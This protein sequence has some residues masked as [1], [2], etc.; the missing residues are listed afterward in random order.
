M[1]RL[2]H[3]RLLASHARLATPAATHGGAHRYRLRHGIAHLHLTGTPELAATA[4]QRLETWFERFDLPGHEAVATLTGDLT[5]T[6]HRLPEAGLAPWHDWLGRNATLFARARDPESGRGMVLQTAT[7]HADDSPV[8]AAAEDWLRGEGADTWYLRR[9]RRP[10]C[11]DRPSY[12]DLHLGGPLADGPSVVP[13]G[14]SLIA[15]L[16]QDGRVGLVRAKPRMRWRSERADAVAIAPLGPTRFASVTGGGH[17]LAW[18]APL[19][20]PVLLAR[21]DSLGAE[22]APARLVNAGGGLVVADHAT[23]DPARPEARLRFI[24]PDGSVSA[25]QTANLGPLQGL[26]AVGDTDLVA[27][28]MRR[29][30]MWDLATT[31]LRWQAEADLEELVAVAPVGDGHLLAVSRPAAAT[32]PHHPETHLERRLMP[33]RND[34]PMWRRPALGEVPF[35]DGIQ[36]RVAWVCPACE[37]EQAEASLDHVPPE[38]TRPDPA[39]TREE[40][41][42]WRRLAT[43]DDDGDASERGTRPPRVAPPGLFHGHAVPELDA[44]WFRGAWTVREASSGATIHQVTLSSRPEGLAPMASAHVWLSH[45]KS[46]E[47]HFLPEVLIGLH[48]LDGTPLPD[49]TC[50][51]PALL[52]DLERTPWRLACLASGRPAALLRGSNHPWL[53]GGTLDGHGFALCGLV[54]QGDRLVTWDAAGFI[55]LWDKG[56]DMDER[57]HR[58]NQH[59]SENDVAVSRLEAHIFGLDRSLWGLRELGPFSIA[60]RDDGCALTIERCISLTLAQWWSLMPLAPRSLNPDG[61]MRIECSQ[62]GTETSFRLR[63]MQGVQTADMKSLNAITPALS[64][65]G[66]TAEIAN[67]IAES[68]ASRVDLVTRLR[69]TLLVLTPR[70]AMALQIR[71]GLLGMTDTDFSRF[72]E[73]SR[74]QEALA[75][76]RQRNGSRARK[77]RAIMDS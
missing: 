74:R 12:L 63:L 15:A 37:A 14:D 52:D 9:E 24:R 5:A 28:D 60:P 71:W 67:L 3:D 32:C 2:R 36:T 41:H 64:S 47:D 40:T 27:W 59:A 48:D 7:E 77:L 65:A 42:T 73:R 34:I 44:P 46:G 66:K 68:M 55:R 35:G 30:A 13:L 1:A 69:R 4:L 51:I 72:P 31:S 39:R 11:W 16:L 23:A 21:L 43:E 26:S 62:S 29:Y 70:E 54:T 18:S 8:T 33:A 57:L 19:D 49:A 76:R 6:A 58:D 61:S 17:V 53:N 10:T 56:A 50:E 38:T 45:L 20:E 22:H 25:L 75:L